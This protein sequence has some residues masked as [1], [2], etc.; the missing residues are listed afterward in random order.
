VIQIAAAASTKIEKAI[1]QSC[2]IL[3]LTEIA[4]AA[5][6]KIAKA[7]VRSRAIPRLTAI[8]IATEIVIVTGIATRIVNTTGTVTGTWVAIV[9]DSKST[10]TRSFTRLKT[11]ATT[12]TVV[13]LTKMAIATAC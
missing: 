7:I 13:V 1:A 8:A 9:I 2:A 3:K 4:A 12:V 11:M 10:T 6:T 5:L